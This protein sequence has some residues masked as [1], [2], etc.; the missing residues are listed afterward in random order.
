MEFCGG[1][2][3]IWEQG[4]VATYSLPGYKDFILEHY[5][6]YQRPG[7]EIAVHGVRDSA[8]ETS[9]R[10][11][12]RAVNYAYLHRFHDTQI[13][14]NVRRAEREGFDAVIIGVLQDPGLWEA[15][16]VVDIP[17]IGYGEVSMLTACMHGSRFAFVAINPEM[18]PLVRTMIHAQGL[19]SRAAPTAYMDCGYPDL[20]DA[21]N[22]KPERFLS[23]FR[24]AAHKAIRDHAVDVLLPGQTIIAELLW[25]AGVAAIEGAL[26]LDP[27]LP[28]LRMAEM[29]VDMRR[30]GFGI[31][32]RGF[33]WA[34][35][36]AD[37]EQGVRDFYA[38]PER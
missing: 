29:L 10:I 26:V 18:D 28:L 5:A 4:L 31:S 20:S 3:R 12:G 19:E 23:A 35:P 6:A 14:E 34:K 17:V 13:I 25:R 27:R 36:P 21:V 22:G 15:R 9:A 37:L 8:S 32:R 33:Y 2:M 30:A 38:S 11:A 7:T 16:S 1:Q 24:A